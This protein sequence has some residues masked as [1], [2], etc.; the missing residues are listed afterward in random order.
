MHPFPRASHVRLTAL[1]LAGAIA[2]CD[3]S[4]PPEAPPGAP[5]AN[6][7][8]RSYEITDLGRVGQALYISNSGRIAGSSFVT[9]AA[10]IWQNGAVTDIDSGH[11]IKVHGINDRGQVVGQSFRDGRSYGWLWEDGV[12]T[13]LPGSANAL[14]NAG[15]VAGGSTE[16]AYLWTKGAMQ[17]LGTLGGPFSFASAINDRGQVVGWAETADNSFHACLWENGSMRDLDSGAVGGVTLALINDA[18]VVT[19][20][21]TFNGHTHAF[22]WDGTLHDL[23]ALPWPEGGVSEINNRG[24]VVGTSSR[25]SVRIDTYAF[26]W[27]DGVFTQLAALPGDSW[28]SAV[29]INNQGEIV[30]SSANPGRTHAVVWRNGT[31]SDLG[32]LG[33]GSSFG[34]DIN[35]VGTVVGSAQDSTGHLHAVMWRPA[36][37]VE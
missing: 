13:E 6:A 31:I 1:I 10:F 3:R 12:L 16:P 8:S 26:V 32:T 29:R 20:Q 35:D 28:P 30:G 22:L 4:V 34:W 27:Q 25:T 36:G 11:V 9:R 21:S 23:G 17:P 33:G 7:S 14:N 19:G 37:A 5:T 18:G 24:Q 15:Q 2:G